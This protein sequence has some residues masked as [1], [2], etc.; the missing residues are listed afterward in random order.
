MPFRI[1]YHS[2]ILHHG[3]WYPKVAYVDDDNRPFILESQEGFNRRESALAGAGIIGARLRWEHDHP[4]VPVPLPVSA[5]P[6]EQK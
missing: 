5:P 6:L 3:K 2:A 4:G 1:V